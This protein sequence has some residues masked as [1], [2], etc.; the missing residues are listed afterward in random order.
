M[1]H[2]QHGQLP[3]TECLTDALQG[4]DHALDHM[5]SAG[6]S[7][8]HPVVDAV[9]LAAAELQSALLLAVSTVQLP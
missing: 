4:L 2:V 6:L 5:N 8:G 7:A 1:S 3:T 9:L